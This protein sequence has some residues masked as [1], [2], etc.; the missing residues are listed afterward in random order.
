VGIIRAHL[1][2]DAGKLGHEL[3]GGGR[4]DGSLADDNRAGTPLLEIVSAPDMCSSSQAVAYAQEIRRLCR[5]LRVSE[6]VMQRGHMRFEPNINV[7]ITTRDGHVYHTPIVEVKNLNSFKSLA[8]AIEH[9]Y[10]RQVEQWASDGVVHGPGRKSTRGWDDMRQ[11]TVAQR[12]KEDAHDYRY[13]PDPDLPPVHISNTWREQI[14][15]SLPELPAAR[16][17]RYEREYA[18]SAVEAATLTAERGLAEFY[19]ACISAHPRGPAAAHPI[20][21]FLLNSAARLANQCETSIDQLGVPAQQ[22]ARLLEM[23]E[24]GEIGS[25]AA[26]QLLELLCDPA[27]RDRDARELA[28]EC[29]LAQV[30]DDAQLD[31]WI[32]QAIAAH[33]QAATDFASGKDAAA[34]RLVGHVMKISRGQAN[35]ASVQDKLRTRLRT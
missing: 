1:E 16:R 9:E 12:E 28:R 33:P 34:G 10:A 23:R 8:G 35:A 15:A 5:F 13:F 22:V 11:C 4:Y 26:D 7:I 19:E 6:G 17:E 29:G 24:A 20:A 2:E 25:N 32:E 30:R 3:P 21:K 31:Q 27:M 18:V 14:A